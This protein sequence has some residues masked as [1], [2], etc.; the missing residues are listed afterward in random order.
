MDNA[1][2][3]LSSALEDYLE[4]IYLILGRAPAARVRDIARAR[5]VRAASV[6]PAIQRLAQLGL[7]QYERRES[8]TLTPAGEAQARRVLSRHHLLIRL[9][10]DL[11]GISPEVAEQDACAIEHHLSDETVDRLAR[12]FEFVQRC[13]KGRQG[14]LQRLRQCAIVNP[15]QPHCQGNCPLR[16]GQTRATAAARRRTLADLRPGE[17]GIV[18]QVEG[19]GPV[20]QRLLDMGMLPNVQVSLERVAPAGD[21]LWI[22]MAG[23][24]LSLRRE[25][26]ARVV[27]SDGEGPELRKR[28]HAAA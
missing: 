27:L 24:Q 11:L 10:R 8:I 9:L 20:R 15:E 17:S 21:P 5:D 14:F 4:T 25:E 19:D 6:T 12:L 18:G 2:A 13:P 3:P 23:Y 1:Q 26:A 28:E 22:R 7:V 16:S